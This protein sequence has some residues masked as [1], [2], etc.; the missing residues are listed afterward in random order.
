MKLPVLKEI[1]FLEVRM[2]GMPLKGDGA[3]MHFQKDFRSFFNP[4]GPHQHFQRVP[5]G[6]EPFNGAGSCM[7]FE[8]FFH[9]SVNMGNFGKKVVGHGISISWLLIRYSYV[10]SNP[11]VKFFIYQPFSD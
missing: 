3:G 7:P 11:E 8:N 4:T 1:V 5:G 2:H 6:T 10:K 9:W